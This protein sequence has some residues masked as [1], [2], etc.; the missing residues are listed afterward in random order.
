MTHFQAAPQISVNSLLDTYP[1]QHNPISA[2]AWY[3]LTIATIVTFLAFMILDPNPDLL[4]AACSAINVAILMKAAYNLYEWGL[5][6]SPM[7]AAVIG[8]G[9]IVF[10]TWGNLGAR[11]AGEGRFGTNFGSLDYFGTAALLSTIG[12][13]VFYLIVFVLFAKYVRRIHIRYEH[14]HWR[15]RHGAIATLLAVGVIVYLS[16]KYPFSNGYFRGVDGGLDQWFSASLYYFITL[17]VIVNVSVSVNQKQ[18]RDRL[19]GYASLLILLVLALGLRSRTSMILM[20]VQAGLCWITLQPHRLHVIIPGGVIVIVSL[21]LLGT[22]VKLSSNQGVTTS[23]WDNLLVI[24]QIDIG[25]IEQA[26]I[27]SFDTDVQYRTAGLEYPAT[28]LFLLDLGVSPLYGEGAYQGTLQGLPDFLRPSGQGSERA[29]IGDH[30]IPQ[31]LQY[32]DSIGVPLTSG[33]AD[34]GMLGGVIIYVVIAIY[35]LLLWRI[36]QIS[37]RF[38]VLFLS[39]GVGAV[40]DLFW[41]N[42]SSVLIKGMGFMFLVLLVFGPVLLPQWLPPSEK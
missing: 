17:G 12:L 28:L 39:V 41:E 24:S 34:F 37:P 27:V 33:I 6:L 10:Y 32:G 13:Y 21:F 35:C 31:G 30:F 18:F 20:I 29:A 42:A 36:T 5:L 19:I 7:S 23:V 3:F 38:F 11:I 9:W 26:N 1:S 25:T 22:V 15:P 16:S 14:L 4:L 8:P 2:L 40:G